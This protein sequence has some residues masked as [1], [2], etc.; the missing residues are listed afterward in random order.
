MADLL[1][2]RTAELNVEGVHP[3]YMILTGFA[4]ASAEVGAALNL[5]SG[6]ASRANLECLC[7]FHHRLKTFG[8]W[9]DT[10]YPDG[11][12]VWTSPSGKTYRT[13][14]GGA[15]LFNSFATVPCGQPQPA[16]P[17]KL[18]RAARVE[19]TRAKNRRLRP[20]NEKYSYTQKARRKELD[21][22]RNHNR[23]RVTLKLFKGDEPSKSPYCTWINDPF[24]PEELPP[25][26]E[27]PPPPPLNPEDP[28]F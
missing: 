11:T 7:R 9:S 5:T 26:W 8:G 2:Q 24:E 13:T 22:R 16:R 28:P 1:V 14:P 19:Q 21:R 15:D 18:S 23:M 6:A 3:N 4:R 10:Q 20:V 12:V 27:P 25:D 17:P